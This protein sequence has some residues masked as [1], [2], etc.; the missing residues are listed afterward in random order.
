MSRQMSRFLLPLAL[1]ASTS[2]WALPASTVSWVQRT[3]TTDGVS[4]VE[5]WLRLTVDVQANGP[6]VL[7]GSQTSFD[8]NDYA[9]LSDFAT[10]DGIFNS[11][12]AFCSTNFFPEPPLNG[13]A[14]LASPWKFEFSFTADSFFQPQAT[15]LQ[16]GDS[17]DYLFATF[18]PQNGPVANGVYSF[19]N[20]TLFLYVTGTDAA[21]GNLTRDLAIGETCSALSASCSFDREVIS[22]P[23]PASYGLMAM[24]VLGLAWRRRFLR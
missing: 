13:C 18:A 2:A 1:A 14:D 3:G 11:G 6:L 7:D 17:R 23:E 24:G 9:Q 19:S 22:V 12:S 5:V 20:A 8:V 21:G 16:P 4:T 10:I 15:P